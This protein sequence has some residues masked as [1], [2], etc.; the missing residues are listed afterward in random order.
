[1]NCQHNTEIVMNTSRFASTSN[2]ITGYSIFKTTLINQ[3]KTNQ[4]Q[5]KC[6]NKK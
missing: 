4:L 6:L 3:V 1:M 5:F 2:S